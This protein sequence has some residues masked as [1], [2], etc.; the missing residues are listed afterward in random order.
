MGTHKGWTVTKRAAGK[1]LARVRVG[2][3]YRGR[4]FDS[5]AFAQAWAKHHAAGI[6]LGRGMPEPPPPPATTAELVTSFLRSLDARGRSASHVI[7][8]TRGLEQLARAVP[9]L[10]GPGVAVAIEQWLAGLKRDD[11]TGPLSPASRN[12][13]LVMVRAMCRWA[14][15]RDLLPKDPTR[16]L[17]RSSVPDYLR[18]QFTVDELR[19]CLACSHY[20][21]PRGK[22]PKRD[23]WHLLFSLLAYTG[24]RYQEAAH[25]RWEDVDL[26][27]NML[28][29]RLE[30]GAR[31][32]RQRERLVPLQAELRT[33]LEAVQA[34]QGEKRGPI[35]AKFR[36]NP[37]RSFRAF[38]GRAGIEVAGRSPHSLRHTYAGMMTATGLP[39]PLLMAYLGHSSA[40]TTLGY[41]KLAVRFTSAVEG[42]P[43]GTL[44]LGL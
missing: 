36:D 2:G 19:R 28:S 10:Q 43:R 20:K 41:T 15:A 39:A 44:R 29:V 23:P 32:K 31:V 6:T 12:K 17:G 18:A 3:G 25:L 9:S 40:A 11:G 7:D 33:L 42:W 4:V 30:A 38:I 8:T 22:R 24:M 13:R 34:E 35:V 5:L 21:A 14:E 37:T 27:G 26:S 16:A 1:W